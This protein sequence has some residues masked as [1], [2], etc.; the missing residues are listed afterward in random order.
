MIILVV[1]HIIEKR[2]KDIVGLSFLLAS[3]LKMVIAG[4]LAKVF[5]LDGTGT[6]T[7]NFNFLLLFILFLAI[8]SI[9]TIRILNKKQ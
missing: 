6:Q 1:V 3:S 7:E 8:E 5:L 4:I 9:L 2:N